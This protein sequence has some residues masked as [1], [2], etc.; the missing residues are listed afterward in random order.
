MLGLDEAG[1]TTILYKIK[2]GEVVSVVPTLGFNVEEVEY[3]D[4]TFTIWDIGWRLN[5]SIW[6][7]IYSN[8]QAVIFVVDAT[9]QE[10]IELAR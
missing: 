3:K 7:R 4:I 8:M 1:K 2:L 6:H 9:D 5:Q 10:G